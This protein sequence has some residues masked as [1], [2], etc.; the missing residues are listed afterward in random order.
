VLVRY[1]MPCHARFCSAVEGL[2]FK[3]S[4][5][6][7]LVTAPCNLNVKLFLRSRCTV[8]C[9]SHSTMLS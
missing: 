4:M 5:K 7:K 3:G 6:S 9:R 8:P 1:P 2:G